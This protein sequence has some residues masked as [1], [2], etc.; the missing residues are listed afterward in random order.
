MATTKPLSIFAARLAAET[1]AERIRQEAAREDA[2]AQLTAADIAWIRRLKRV[3]KDMPSSLRVLAG[4]NDG[5]TVYQ[6]V[7]EHGREVDYV[8]APRIAS[9]NDC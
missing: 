3:V 9:R 6:G 4:R 7:A 2:L 1:E 8:S 5:L